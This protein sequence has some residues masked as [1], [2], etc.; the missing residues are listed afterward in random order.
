MKIT[1]KIYDK[2]G[3]SLIFQQ[4]WKFS[5][6]SP[7]IVTTNPKSLIP[8]EVIPSPIDSF[9]I[10][11]TFALPTFIWW[12]FNHFSWKMRKKIFIVYLMPVDEWGAGSGRKSRHQITSFISQNNSGY[13]SHFTLKNV[14]TYNGH[15]LNENNKFY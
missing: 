9:G 8:F 14:K 7:S 10:C 13:A 1:R 12:V 3:L 2:I 5:F 11:G 6:Q 15:A 4:I